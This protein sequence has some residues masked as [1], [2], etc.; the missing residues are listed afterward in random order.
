MGPRYSTPA[1]VIESECIIAWF[2]K[3]PTQK[4]IAAADK[5]LSSYPSVCSLNREMVDE[6]IDFCE[7][8]SEGMLRR[9]MNPQFLETLKHNFFQSFTVK[10]PRTGGVDSFYSAAK[11]SET[12]SSAH[13]IDIYTFFVT[14]VMISD[15]S[16]RDKL[17]FCFRLCNFEKCL[18]TKAFHQSA[19][20]Q[21]LF[22][23]IN[24]PPIST[25]SANKLKEASLSKQMDKT[26]SQKGCGA[27]EDQGNSS[28]DDSFSCS[29][30]SNEIKKRGE[31]LE[32]ELRISTIAAYILVT[33]LL[34]GAHAAMGLLP[35]SLAVRAE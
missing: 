24:L 29:V 4:V 23:S 6:V 30:T 5:I 18:A 1:V 19:S 16:L 13:T 22:D 8:G 9:N 27:E 31:D 15:G 11:R 33:S 28:P 21:G 10:S 17:D 7:S 26:N 20:S 2:Y 34:K 25:S 35:P 14:L 32:G 12:T 3:Y